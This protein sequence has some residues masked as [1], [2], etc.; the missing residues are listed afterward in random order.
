MNK[1]ENE[2][3]DRK[4]FIKWL[5][6]ILLVA[7][8]GFLG[9]VLASA[10]SEKI[11]AFLQMIMNAKDFVTIPCIVLFVATTVFGYGY[12][13]MNYRKAKGFVEAGYDDDTYDKAEEILSKASVGINVLAG[14]NYLFF[15]VCLFLAG[16]G[17]SEL[18]KTQA[19]LSLITIATFIVANICSISMQNKTVALDKKMNPEKRGN[20]FD[21]KFAKEWIESCDEA[22]KSLIYQSAYT[23]YR[24]AISFSTALW[25]ISLIGMMSFHTGVLAVVVSSIIMIVLI[26]TYSVTA[27]KLQHKK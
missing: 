11:D 18:T 21:K 22:E 16:M 14:I 2:K 19:V 27:Y 10:N 8:A 9:G 20:V 1:I 12:V 3:N 23:A 13:F 6:L 4:I 24:V 7:F 15:G 25:G 5:I 26:S 17:D